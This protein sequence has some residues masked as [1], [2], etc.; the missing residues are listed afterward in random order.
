MV[1]VFEG[2]RIYGDIKENGAEY[3]AGFLKIC[4]NIPLTPLGLLPSKA[5][6]HIE[7]KIEGW[8][9]PDDNQIYRD[10]FL[11][12]SRANSVFENYTRIGVSFS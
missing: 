7:K 5:R 11:D 2:N 8:Y 4:M 6:S 1:E 10:R 9:V 3:A 12:F